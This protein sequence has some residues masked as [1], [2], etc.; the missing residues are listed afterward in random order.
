MVSI[1]IFLSCSVCLRAVIV[2]EKLMYT[3]FNQTHPHTFPSDEIHPLIQ[4][5]TQAQEC[6]LRKKSRLIKFVQKRLLY[7]QAMYKV[8]LLVFFFTGKKNGNSYEV[9]SRCEG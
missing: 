4:T 3:R 6:N 2:R 9:D 7:K 8:C 1:C 5:C